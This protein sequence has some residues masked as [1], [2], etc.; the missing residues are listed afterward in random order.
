MAKR[1][2]PP[3]GPATAAGRLGELAGAVIGPFSTAGGGG[4]GATGGA[5]AGL[6]AGEALNAAGS[7]A[8]APGVGAAPGVEDKDPAPS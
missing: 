4:L 8:A 6:A 3:A 1:K 5:A 7:A 2:Q